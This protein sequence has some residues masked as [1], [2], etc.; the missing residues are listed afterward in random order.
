[1]IIAYIA[2]FV[3]CIRRGMKEGAVHEIR[4]MMSTICAALCFELA[5]SIFKSHATGEGSSVFIGILLLI[6]VGV[7]YRL[8]SMLFGV[9]NILSRLPLIRVA[10]NLLGIIFGAISAIVTIYV[11]DAVLRYFVMVK[12][13]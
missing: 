7:A 2:V 1:M 8:F 12:P 3:Y 11:V 9:L 4:V 6:V 10:D 13:G 5:A